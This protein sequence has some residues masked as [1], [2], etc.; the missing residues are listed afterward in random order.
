MM[1]VNVNMINERVSFSSTSKREIIHVRQENH[2]QK[3]AIDNIQ[4]HKYTDT[5]DIRTKVR[6][7][8]KQRD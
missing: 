3:Q 4:T 5:K 8:P 6:T 7:V 2:H 1:W